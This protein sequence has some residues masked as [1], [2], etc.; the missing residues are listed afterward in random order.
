MLTSLIVDIGIPADHDV[1]RLEAIAS[2]LPHADRV[3]AGS[4]RIAET[5]LPH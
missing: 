5:L 4:R 1:G 3:D 2:H